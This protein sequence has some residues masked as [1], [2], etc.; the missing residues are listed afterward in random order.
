MKSN[1]M[2]SFLTIKW[3]HFFK[4]QRNLHKLSSM[5]DLVWQKILKLY[6]KL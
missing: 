2:L 5:S 1:K 4:K 6:K 3:K